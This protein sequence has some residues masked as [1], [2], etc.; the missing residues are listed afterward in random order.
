M[1]LVRLSGP[2]QLCVSLAELKEQVRLPAEDN[3]QDAM[4]VA[5]LR[6]AQDSIDGARGWLGVALTTQQWRLTLDR[7]PCDVLEI[8]LPPCRSVDS[9]AFIAPDGGTETIVDY[10]V[11]SIGGTRPAR[12]APAYGARWPATR[13]QGDAVS[14]TFTAGWPSFSDVPESI[15]A[16]VLLMAAALYDNCESA[17]AEHLLLPH[18][19][20]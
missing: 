20:W 10:Q 2:P 8:P 4:L 18:R 1:S 17:A 6:A 14:V 15:R 12:L 3:S 7:F 9:V 16:A 11:H 13:C 5:H 19:T